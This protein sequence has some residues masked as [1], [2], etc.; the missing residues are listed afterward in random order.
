MS[1][2]T[3][4]P[5]QVFGYAL[6]AVGVILIMLAVIQAAMTIGPIMEFID[7]LSPNPTIGQYIEALDG[8][9]MPGFVEM[10]GWFLMLLIELLGGYFI[11][12]I[13]QKFAISRT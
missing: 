2:I 5:K 9:V 7:E 13:G 1:E 6:V 8:T 10:T 11:A 3:L 12:N 4:K